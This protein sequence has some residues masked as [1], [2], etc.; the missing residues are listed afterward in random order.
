MFATLVSHPWVAEGGMYAEVAA[1]R[2][3]DLTHRRDGV[4]LKETRYQ[5]ENRFHVRRVEK[6]LN[7]HEQR[8]R[9]P[10]RAAQEVR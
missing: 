8:D 9:C 2:L 1:S 7:R 3:I 10:W 6:R 5:E 4:S